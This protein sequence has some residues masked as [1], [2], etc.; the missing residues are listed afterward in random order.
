MTNFIDYSENLIDIAIKNINVYDLYHF[1]KETLIYS[2]CNEE[3]KRFLSSKFKRN[4]EEL[5]DNCSKG[6]YLSM[7]MLKYV[8][9]NYKEN[10]LV[11]NLESDLMESKY[12]KM[13]EINIGR[14]I[15]LEASRLR[16][17]FLEIKSILYGLETDS[18][19]INL[20]SSLIKLEG[21]FNLDK[22]INSF[23]N[24]PGQF[25]IFRKSASLILDKVIKSN[26]EKLNFIP[27]SETVLNSSLYLIS[28]IEKQLHPYKEEKIV[29]S[30]KDKLKTLKEKL[31]K[32]KI[33]KFSKKKGE[34]KP[35]PFSLP[36]I[37][38]K[39]DEKIF[40]AN[41][42][43][44]N[45]ERH[46]T[47]IT[48]SNGEDQYLDFI[49]NYLFELKDETS[50]TIHVNDKETLKFYSFS[51]SKDPLP[52]A[53]NEDDLNKAKEKIK[54]IIEII[55]K[56]EKVNYGQ[57]IDFLL[58]HEKN[59]FLKMDNKID[60]LLSFLDLKLKNLSD[61]KGSYKKIKQKV[62]VNI[63]KIMNLIG[64]FKEESD[65]TNY[66]KFM[67]IYQLK[68]N[69][70]D[71]FDYLDNIVNYIFCKMEE[72][73]E[74]DSDEESEEEDLLDISEIFKSK[75]E[76]LREKIIDLFKKDIKFISY[77][78]IYLNIK[79]HQH[80]DEN[81]KDLKEKL[82]N[83]KTNIKQKNLLYLKLEKIKDIILSL[84]LYNFDI[85]S[86][87]E[88]FVNEYEII[89]PEKKI[90]IGGNKGKNVGIANF[91]SFIKYLKEYI[92][93]INENVEITGQEPSGFVL[94]LFLQKIGLSWS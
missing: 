7:D 1:N 82:L 50:K 30:I 41:N 48:V 23:L 51:D 11:N 80:I 40:L 33:A 3:K 18:E 14:T 70:K 73:K 45:E 43:K 91:K 12:C 55:P 47:K 44:E 32:Y 37:E 62:K 9:N 20:K 87:F 84:K 74:V 35:K 64:I 24:V 34:K 49:I 8:F 22:Y 88:E 17:K 6:K 54:S 5:L 60:Y 57:L 52:E 13:K 61:I 93:D 25:S 42:L 10:N 4:Y 39:D 78:P 92:G 67:D 71:I 27:P 28:T 56:Y 16:G 72:E 53:N 89:L 31:E 2:Y 21:E 86:H 75:E 66:E 46:Y 83:L 81:I 36:L 29:N 79:L 19:I 94:K 65:Y 59:N 85:K 63:N 77:I 68:A 26:Q 76:K 38:L 90:D 69:S 15:F 58:N